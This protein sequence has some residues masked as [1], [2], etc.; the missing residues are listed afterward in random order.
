MPHSTF[1]YP[2]EWKVCEWAGSLSQART[3]TLR[4]ILLTLTPDAAGN[5]FTLDL[6]T[7]D[8]QQAKE[9]LK[10]AGT[11]FLFFDPF[12]APEYTWL[13]WLHISREAMEQLLGQEF[14]AADFINPTEGKQQPYP[15]TWGV[16]F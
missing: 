10:R 4:R 6:P 15:E 16:M 11:R 13:E 7:G 3:G 2:F 1:A 5:R 9:R 14:V 12:D 8:I